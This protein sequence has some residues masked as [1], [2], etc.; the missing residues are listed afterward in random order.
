MIDQT[1]YT[2]S[3]ALF[4]RAKRVIPGGVN[5][6]VRAFRG[7]GGTPPFIVHAAGA[8]VE[9]ADGNRYLDLVG[10][11]GP[12]IV[13]HAHPDVQAAVRHAAAHGFSYG[14]PTGQETTLA[15]AIVDRVPG[16]EMVR[17]VNSGTEATMSALRLAR[18]ATR[19]DAFIK[20]DGCYHGHADPF[21][22]AAGSGA[23]DIGVPDSPGV[24]AAVAAQT[25]VVPFNDLEAVEEM[26][27]SHP[28]PIAA[29]IVEPV[30]G[31]AGCIP[32][33]P[34]F[35]EGLR[36]VCDRFGAL[37]IFDEV[38]TG[39]RV[40]RGGA[41]E[42]FG[43]QPDLVTF[44]KVI[45]GGFPIGA[46]AGSR[47]L[48][49]QI[50]PA[51]PVYQAG[52][53][54]GNPVAVAAGLATLNLLTPA[55]YESLERA[56]R[57]VED[58]VH[59]MTQKAAAAGR[60]LCFQRVG[61]MFSLFFAA[62]PVQSLTDA[63]RADTEAFRRF[64]HGMLADGVYLAPSAFESSFLSLAHTDDDLTFFLDRMTHHLT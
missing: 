31:N 15:E 44:G 57:R 17:L 10:S 60:P 50:A 8:H 24:P 21:L 46:Y 56:G 53:L 55:A 18:A 30:G 28:D 5:S 27:R 62:G 64:F 41:I 2:H 40:T 63:S 39:F 12:M 13:G 49:E 54:S 14:A 25:L 29:V 48:M 22:V 61:S 43:V 51:G 37:L 4:E 6:P 1:R 35:L 42:R 16:I 58:A 47:A 20:F 23:L 33:V 11:W 32:P 45:G 34:G 9:D 26:F 59:D 52:T 38:M 36:A 3:S 19:R 7:V